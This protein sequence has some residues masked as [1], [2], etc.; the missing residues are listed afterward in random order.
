MEHETTPEEVVSKA[1]GLYRGVS[2]VIAERP[3]GM[4]A[5]IVDGGYIEIATG[6]PGEATDEEPMDGDDEATA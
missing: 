4:L 1:I 2:R 5:Y 6:I 3:G